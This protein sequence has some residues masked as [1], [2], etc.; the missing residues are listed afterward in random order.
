MQVCELEDELLGDKRITPNEPFFGFGIGRRNGP[1]IHHDSAFILATAH[2]RHSVGFIHAQ[3]TT[4]HHASTVHD[5]AV[6]REAKGLVRKKRRESL[7]ERQSND[8]RVG[9]SGSRVNVKQWVRDEWGG[10]LC[11]GLQGK[12]LCLGRSRFPFWIG[13]LVVT[14]NRFIDVVGH[15]VSK[16]G[17]S[18]RIGSASE[19]KT[20]NGYWLQKQHVSEKREDVG[21]KTHTD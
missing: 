9:E 20:V 7:L 2:H 16:D 19:M 12:T 17:I 18:R 5:T 13:S 6:R 10:Q 11:E 4:H 3:H 8:G 21:L 1:L 14:R 15:Q